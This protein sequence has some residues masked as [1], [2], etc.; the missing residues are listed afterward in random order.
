MSAVSRQSWSKSRTIP[1]RSLHGRHPVLRVGIAVGLA[2]AV[3]S[4][5]AAAGANTGTGT[6]APAVSAVSGIPAAFGGGPTVA[7]TNARVRP[8]TSSTAKA[9]AKS[10]PSRTPAKDA[11]GAVL[12]RGSTDQSVSNAVVDPSGQAMP[13][14]NIS[15]WRQVFADDF[16]QNVPLG[17]FPAAVSSQWTGYNGSK[18]T[19]G[20]GTYDPSQVVSIHNG[21]MDLYLHTE[22]GVHLVAAPQPII[23]GATGSDGGMVYGMYEVRF[24][25]DPVPGYKA[26]WLLWPDSN[27]WPDGEIDF[28][29]GNLNAN[30]DGFMHHVGD[31]E[32]QDAFTTTDTF[33]NWQTATIEWTPSS[34]TFLLDGQVIGTSTSQ[35]DIPDTA[36]H[37]VLQTETQ[38]DGGAPSD[39]AA[40]HVDIDWVV[41]YAPAN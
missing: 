27:N 3:A 4:G 17:Q 31:P 20:N 37:W 1:A 21:I 11:S 8:S 15:G 30:F 24:R 5:C 25:A 34:L 18:D 38:L 40:G 39:S 12:G 28:P 13:V 6:S 29:E 35:V 22:N 23:P 41:I 32:A 36:M 7:A 10:K 2:A 9:S 19:S 26:A 33:D 16:N 14:G